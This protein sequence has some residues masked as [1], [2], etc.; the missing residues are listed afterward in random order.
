MVKAEKTYGRSRHLCWRPQKGSYE[1]DPGSML[2][3][4]CS[5]QLSFTFLT[6]D[7]L[8]SIQCC[9][10]SRSWWRSQRRSLLRTMNFQ[11]LSVVCESQNSSKS[12]LLI[13]HPAFLLRTSKRNAWGGF[14][15][16]SQAYSEHFFNSVSP[17][18]AA[19]PEQSKRRFFPVFFKRWCQTN[20]HLA[21]PRLFHV[22]SFYLYISSVRASLP[23]LN[24]RIFQDVRSD[25]I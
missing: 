7:F 10:G 18:P 8:S 3:L 17:E 4:L 24:S 20:L 2:G 23:M 5:T 9:P 11:C 25:I 6:P 19:W 16:F 13:L 15:N 12:L 21:L 1:D 14:L 22:F